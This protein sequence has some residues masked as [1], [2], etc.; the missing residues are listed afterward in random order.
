MPGGNTDVEALLRRIRGG[1][2]A[3]PDELFTLVY[4]ELRA[5]ARRVF[6]TQRREHTLQP[7][8][9]LHEAWLKLGGGADV[10]F[11]AQQLDVRVAAQRA[12]TAAGRI[13]QDQVEAGRVPIP[14]R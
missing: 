2:D 12:G 14:G 1:D 7:T 4:D 5:V 9:V 6:R 8:A 11:G 13:Q 3:A 10:L